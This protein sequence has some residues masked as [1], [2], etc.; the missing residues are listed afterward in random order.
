MR[1]FFEKIF[2][3][4]IINWDKFKI[5]DSFWGGLF[6]TIC[7]PIYSWK[8]DRCCYGSFFNRMEKFFT[9]TIKSYMPFSKACRWL[10]FRLVNRVY[11]CKELDIF[12]CRTRGSVTKYYRAKCLFGYIRFEE[13]QYIYKG[14]TCNLFMDFTVAG[15]VGDKS[16]KK[17]AEQTKT[18]IKV[19]YKGWVFTKKKAFQV[20]KEVI[21]KNQ[22]IYNPN[23]HSYPQAED[24]F[25]VQ[26]VDTMLM[27]LGKG[28]FE[29]EDSRSYIDN[30]LLNDRFNSSK[31]VV[32][33]LWCY[34]TDLLTMP[35]DFDA[36][37]QL[38]TI[39][40]KCDH[41]L[42]YRAMKKNPSISYTYRTY[43]KNCGKKE[44]NK[45]LKECLSEITGWNRIKYINEI[46]DEIFKLKDYYLNKPYSYFRI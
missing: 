15:L 29:Q 40:R 24:D 25:Y 30:T 34:V 5:Y 18:N 11:D 16:A 28:K 20:Y 38:A 13:I 44:A 7:H 17:K 2:N 23:L 45:F 27:V 37:Q 42:F 14:K 19:I 41:Y 8:Y 3:Y 36:H 46:R 12:Y 33:K 32:E 35:N 1:K 4:E 31:D 6:F 43:L 26:I 21:E 10:G 39:C 22:K 9:R